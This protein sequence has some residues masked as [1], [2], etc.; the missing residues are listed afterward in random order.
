MSGNEEDDDYDI[1]GNDNSN[2]DDSP[3]IV[4]DAVAVAYPYQRELNAINQQGDLSTVD[5]LAQF[6]A[7]VNQ[8]YLNDN[9][10]SN[11]YLAG[12]N[13]LLGQM[14]RPMN[15][16]YTLNTLIEVTR[17]LVLASIRD[18]SLED[19]TYYLNSFTATVEQMIR[20]TANPLPIETIQHLDSVTQAFEN[21]IRMVTWRQQQ[22]EQQQQEQQHQVEMEIEQIEE[23][24]L[25]SGS[26]NNTQLH[27]DLATQRQ[28]LEELQRHAQLQHEQLQQQGTQLQQQ[29]GQ[30][31]A[32]NDL[33]AEMEQQAA[34]RN[35]PPAP[36]PDTPFRARAELFNQKNGNDPR[37]WA[38]STMSQGPNNTIWAQ[39][40]ARE[41]AAITP[42]T[43]DTQYLNITDRVLN[44]F[45]PSV[46]DTI[47]CNKGVRRITNAN[48]LFQIATNQSRTTL[49]IQA[50]RTG[51]LILVQSIYNMMAFAPNTRV[52]LNARDEDGRTPLDI[53]IF[54]RYQDIIDWLQSKGA[55]STSKQPD[56]QSVKRG[57][58][59]NGNATGIW[60]NN[61]NSNNSSSS[62]GNSSTGFGW[63]LFSSNS[64]NN[65]IQMC[66]PGDNICSDRIRGS[67]SSSSRDLRV[68]LFGN[69]SEIPNTGL[70]LQLEPAIMGSNSSSGTKRRAS[71]QFTASGNPDGEPGG[72]LTVVN[73]ED[74]DSC[75]RFL[76]FPD[77]ASILD[78]DTL[79]ARE[80]LLLGENVGNVPMRQKIRDAVAVCRQKFVGGGKRRTMKVK[81]QFRKTNK[82]VYKKGKKT[83]VRRNNKSKRVLKE[84]RRR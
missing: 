29:A 45:Q 47:S 62:S 6:F 48:F 4:A 71:E 22:Q 79:D 39:E 40:C 78:E 10:N 53:A 14:R 9:F 16:E 64:G 63:G 25:Q 75:A 33:L 83:R 2:N 76:G 20:N 74:K 72:S 49:F 38:Q 21:E 35:A 67:S 12:I 24:L 18:L 34:A 77:Y 13:Y 68:N 28:H 30:L 73:F 7:F 11:W 52:D 8:Q 42:T 36:M 70:R 19:L 46:A 84:K 50:I 69:S 27:A 51:R 65:S 82:R 81:K 80:D 54:Y 3:P 44:F 55:R 15:D 26:E 23:H 41:L 61:G 37:A 43:N 31:Q 56:S 60:S 17:L 58:N 32:L 1:A 66:E 59:A 57:R 5:N